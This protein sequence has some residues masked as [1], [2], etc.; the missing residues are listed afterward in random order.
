MHMCSNR[1]LDIDMEEDTKQGLSL[2]GE[3]A[4]RVGMEGPSLLWVPDLFIFT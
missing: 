3:S 2:L 4:V 1:H